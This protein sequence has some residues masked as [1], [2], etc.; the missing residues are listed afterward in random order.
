MNGW[1]DR[2]TDA[3]PISSYVANSP[4][5]NS[6]GRTSGQIDELSLGVCLGTSA[7]MNWHVLFARLLGEQQ[8]HNPISIL[9]HAKLICTSMQTVGT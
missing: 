4:V 7:G 9:E 6:D 1:M 3:R 8:C 5:A 2:W